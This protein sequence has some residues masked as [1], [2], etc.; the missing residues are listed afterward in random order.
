MKY[1][2]IS[3]AGE[4]EVEITKERAAFIL[5]GAYK[6]EVVEELLDTPGVIP[7]MFSIIVVRKSE[8][9]LKGER[10]V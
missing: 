6:K 7:T 4:N 2:K 3:K 10:T 9:G 1:F 8:K 5:E